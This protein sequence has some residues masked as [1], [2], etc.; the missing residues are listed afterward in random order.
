MELVPSPKN[1]NQKDSGGPIPKHAE[2]TIVRSAGNFE[3]ALDTNVATFQN[4]VRVEHPT[5]PGK[6][7]TIDC[8][9]LTLVF[10]EEPRAASDG[11]APEQDA[12]GGPNAQKL[13]FRRMSAEG[14]PTVVVS[15]R[16]GLKAEMQHLTWDAQSKVVA[17]SDKNRVV[18]WQKNTEFKAAEVTAVLDD[19]GEIE[20]TFCQGAGSMTR[21]APTGPA[22]PRSRHAATQDVSASWTKSLQFAPDPESK[23]DLLTLVGNAQLKQPGRIDLKSEVLSVWLT[24]VPKQKALRG[25]DQSRHAA[26]SEQERFEPKRLLGLKDATFHIEQPTGRLI[27]N[28]Q[29]LEVWFDPAPPQGS[30]DRQ[31]GATS[32]AQP[33]PAPGIAIRPTGTSARDP[34]GRTAVPPPQT[35]RA[36]EEPVKLSAALIRVHALVHKG[37]SQGTGN[38]RTEVATIYT[39][40][41]VDIN[42][43]RPAGQAPLRILGDRLT[44]SNQSETSQVVTIFGMPATLNDRGM[45][46]EG[47]EITFD[48]EAN[49]ATVTGKGTLQFPVKN[50]FEGRPLPAAQML[51]VSWADSMTFDGAKADFFGAVRSHLDESE[52]QCE[53]MSV[54]LSR[55][56]SFT[57]QS[58]ATKDA[59]IQEIHCRDGVEFKSLAYLQDRLVGVRTARSFEFSVNMQSGATWAQGP[60]TLSFWQRGRTNRAGLT[61]VSGARANRPLAA[62]TTEWEF[63]RVTFAGEMRGNLHQKTTTFRDRVRVVHGPVA[64]SVAQIDGAE[65]PKNSGWMTSATLTLTQH[66][67]SPT[68]PA[69]FSFEARENVILDGH[70]DNGQFHAIADNASFDES[71]GFYIL[72]SEGR[73]HATIWREDASGGNRRPVPG[74][75][76]EFNPATNELKIEGTSGT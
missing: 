62:A 57:A 1:L 21:H 10:E 32:A 24:P 19:H 12:V 5:E 14:Q 22:K 11:V 67:A 75:R 3:Y 2:K 15:Q 6:L 73:K 39:E 53:E 35:K 41:Q 40:G 68:K 46:L 59:E 60:G 64:S 50:D 58:A 54:T 4:R 30:A 76:M 7:D 36:R 65:P 61:S 38:E 74:R 33:G 55:R 42:Q 29:R 66:P 47:D 43:A 37:D 45:I 52:M 49:L 69:Y 70:S 8:D 34:N 25:T 31:A 26:N 72:W 44:L 20:S 27:G 23:L 71:K 17:L 13:Q 28:T 16:S 9:L 18:L 51:V 56:I 48:R 63:T